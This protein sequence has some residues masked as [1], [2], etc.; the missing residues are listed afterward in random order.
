[1]DGNK[2]RPKHVRLRD[3]SLYQKASEKK[4]PLPT[5]EKLTI[6]LKNRPKSRFNV[7]LNSC[8]LHQTRTTPSRRNISS[9]QVYYIV[10]LCVVEWC[11]LY[12][13]KA[14]KKTSIPADSLASPHAVTVNVNDCQFTRGRHCCGVNF[15]ENHIDS[16]ARLGRASTAEAE[17]RERERVI[18]LDGFPLASKIAPFRQTETVASMMNC[19]R[20]N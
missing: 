12:A 14:E 11:L 5:A 16:N 4:R 19:S 13:N 10:V 15:I 17:R 1:M 8:F 18:L 3:L 6:I 7:S 9:S 20:R 2:L